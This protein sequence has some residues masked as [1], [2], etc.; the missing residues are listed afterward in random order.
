MAGRKKAP[1]AARRV[2]H[3]IALDALNVM[4]RLRSRQD[5]MV[6]LFSRTRDRSPLL[7]VVHSW[8]L[9]ITFSELATLEPM[10]QRAISHFYETLGELRWYLQYT[11]EMPLQVRK[12]VTQAMVGLEASHRRLTEATGPPDGQGAPVVEG[13]VSLVPAEPRRQRR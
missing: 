8:F 11:E 12:R 10:E 1:D 5:E 13:A 4:T 6:R 3:L 7:G 2:R 9:T